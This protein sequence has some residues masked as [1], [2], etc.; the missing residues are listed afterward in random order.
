LASLSRV[1]EMARHWGSEC[2]HVGAVGHLNPASGYGEWLQAED[3]IS[4]LDR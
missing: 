4:Q 2:V 3:L 1:E